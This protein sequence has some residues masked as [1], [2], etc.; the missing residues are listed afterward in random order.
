MGKF[1]D[2]IKFLVID[3]FCG[4]GGTTTGAEDSGVCKVIAA[5]NHD[6]LAIS[7]HAANHADVLHM[8]EDIVVADIRP[9]VAS[10]E[11]WKQIYPSAR[12]ILWASL[13]CTNFSTTNDGPPRW[14]ITDA[15]SPA[16]VDLKDFM[17]AHGIADI[18]MRMLMVKELKLIQ[19]F[20]ADYVLHGPLNEQKKFIGNSVETGVVR[21][22]LRAMAGVAQ[23]ESIHM[24]NAAVA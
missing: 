10:V 14:T 20:P 19:G 11:Y 13:E 18:F 24:E 16:M 9:I 17:R 4:A 22:W 23:S 5:V 1:N 21:A 6:P 15:D 7:S 8:T 12:V 2:H 3:L